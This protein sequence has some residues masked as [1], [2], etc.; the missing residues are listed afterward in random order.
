MRVGRARGGSDG[1]WIRS[2]TGRAY[3]YFSI[4]CHPAYARVSAVAPS[5]RSKCG[6]YVLCRAFEQA[7][8]SA[9]VYISE[10][11]SAEQQPTQKPTYPLQRNKSTS[12]MAYRL[13]PA[14]Q[15]DIPAWA[16]AC[17]DASQAPHKPFSMIMV[18]PLTGVHPD[19]PARCDAQVAGLT[20]LF[21]NGLWHIPGATHLKVEHA[22]SGALVGG[23]LYVD[24][25]QWPGPEEDSVALW[26]PE[27]GQRDYATRALRANEVAHREM[28]SGAHICEFLF[29]LFRY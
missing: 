27:G 26:Q 20:E 24:I 13:A 9:R 29:L 7:R 12:T 18:P 15:S 10:R 28:I 3:A 6:A 19:S 21:A 11:P 5:S 14:T 23:A 16:T 17:Y 1:L 2:F 25:P 8:A 4:A 22:E